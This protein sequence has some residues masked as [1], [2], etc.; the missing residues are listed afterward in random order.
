MIHV[1]S[2]NHAS[3]NGTEGQEGREPSKSFVIGGDVSS[4]Q[5]HNA[6]C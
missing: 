5:T 2:Y 1:N 4:D 3:S 6:R